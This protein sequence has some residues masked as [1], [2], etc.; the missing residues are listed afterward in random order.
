VFADAASLLAFTHVA[1]P[2]KE[3]FSTRTTPRRSHPRGALST[4]ST[5]DPPPSSTRARR[6]AHQLSSRSPRR[7]FYFLDT[8]RRRW[9][10]HISICRGSHGIE[11]LVPSGQSVET[12]RR[13][14]GPYTSH[15]RPELRRANG[16]S[17][18]LTARRMSP[19]R[20]T[21]TIRRSSCAWQ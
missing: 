19:T 18:R 14:N 6:G 8:G 10:A 3:I 5:R 12:P 17:H 21:M 15:P 1:S 16:G 13:G 20:Q 9:W 7:Q 4:T 11:P 2:T